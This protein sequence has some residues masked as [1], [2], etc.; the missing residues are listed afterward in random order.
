MV[1]IRFIYGRLCILYISMVT[2][3]SYRFYMN[4]HSTGSGAEEELK[5]DLLVDD[6]NAYS[7]LYPTELSSDKFVFKW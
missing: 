1:Y 3:I 6:T 7:Y 2:K 5:M 4:L